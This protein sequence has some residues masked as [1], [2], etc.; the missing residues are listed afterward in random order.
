[1]NQ[2]SPDGLTD[3]SQS[4]PLRYRCESSG[5]SLQRIAGYAEVDV[6]RLYQ[7]RVTAE[8]RA[9]VERVLSLIERGVIAKIPQRGYRA[10]R[11]RQETV[12]A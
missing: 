7:G 12:P 6:R 5:V 4:A 9:A 1:M 11:R 8:E 2:S 3:G 10:P